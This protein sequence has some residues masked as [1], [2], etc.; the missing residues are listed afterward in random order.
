MRLDEST[1]VKRLTLEEGWN[2]Q[3]QEGAAG[4]TGAKSEEGS[5]LDTKQQS[6]PLSCAAQRSPG[7]RPKD[8]RTEDRGC[9]CQGVIDGVGWKP[10]WSRFWREELETGCVRNVLEKELTEDEVGRWFP[11][12]WRLSYTVTSGI[13]C[14]GKVAFVETYLLPLRFFFPPL[15]TAVILG[16]FSALLWQCLS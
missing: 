13:S 2:T 1:S 16:C 9:P 6:D 12:F 4:E 5:V 8:W 11:T 14:L 7:T 3:D 10:G 15:L